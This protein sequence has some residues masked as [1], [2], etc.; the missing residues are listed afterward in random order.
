MNGAPAPKE[1]GFF[2]DKNN[3]EWRQYQLTEEGGYYPS[4]C[5]LP[6]L[7]RDKQK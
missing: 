1:L 7:Q 5:P 2:G 4:T 3:L 6:I